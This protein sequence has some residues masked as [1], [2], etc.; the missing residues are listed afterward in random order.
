MKN[1]KIVQIMKTFTKKEFREFEKFVTS[2][3]HN[4]GRNNL[5][6][7]KELKKFYPEFKS[8]NLNKEYILHKLN[9]GKKNYNVAVMDTMLSRTL[10][11]A[12]KFLVFKNLERYPSQFQIMLSDELLERQ[13][14]QLSKKT[15]NEAALIINQEGIERFN[16]YKLHTIEYLRYQ[17]NAI[18]NNVTD[19]VK[20][21]SNLCSYFLIYMLM[22]LVNEANAIQ[23]YDSLY[24]TNLFEHPI[25]KFILN[26]NFEKSIEGLSY[27][28][29]DTGQIT[30]LY[31][32]LLRLQLHKND[33]SSFERAKE[34]FIN[35][36]DRLANYEKY[37]V[38]TLLINACIVFERKNL[39]EYAYQRFELH[40][41]TLEQSIYSP[42]ENATMNLD[43][44]RNIVL[45]ALSFKEFDW[46]RTFIKEYLNKLSPEQQEN[47]LDYSY[48]HYYFYT[49][50]FDK[51]LEYLGK[52]KLDVFS[53]KE[54]VKRLQLMIYFEQE[55]LEESY[56]LI[57]SFKHFIS[58]NPKVTEDNRVKIN[59]FIKTM[60]KLIRIREKDERTQLFQ[61]KKDVSKKRLPFKDWFLEKISELEE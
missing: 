48:A 10:K 51:S 59:N 35:C 49:K 31:Y 3:F 39:K 14:T 50:D 43:K 23:A 2:A 57:D 47:M 18:E 6:L 19:M 9:P 30:E 61:L 22:E 27:T 56:Y 45:T 4:E 20:D 26:S 58:E 52:V 15:A 53:H 29:K 38:S 37:V 1:Q 32:Y 44:F 41:L 42:F 25:Y 8:E 46:T 34:L 16:I 40:K 33:F 36:I 28:D 11:L 21:F 54:D 24:N 55:R 13:L 12:E 17:S 60:S 7:V 5:P